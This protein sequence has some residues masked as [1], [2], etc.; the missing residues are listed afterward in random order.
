MNQY[1]SFN[2]QQTKLLDQKNNLEKGD[3]AIKKLLNHLDLKKDEAIM[4]TFRSVQKHFAVVFKELV[5]LGKGC[6]VLQR[7]DDPDIDDNDL[8]SDDDGEESSDD[9]NDDDDDDSSEDES[10]ED[11]D[12]DRSMLDDENQGSSASNSSSS[13]SLNNSKL[14]RK[15]MR[16]AKKAAKKQKRKEERAKKMHQKVE[17]FSGVGVKVT[18]SGEG[19]TSMTKR[20][21]GGQKDI[22]ALALI[23][24]I[25]RCDPGP[26][27][28]FDELDAALDDVRRAAVAHLISKQAHD[29]TN[30]V[31]FITSTFRPELVNVADS[32]IGVSQSKKASVVRSLSKKNAAAFMMNPKIQS[33]AAHGKIEHQV[34][35]YYWMICY[36]L[37]FLNLIFSYIFWTTYFHLKGP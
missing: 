9:D 5:P 2:D 24:S 34:S 30:P 22:V 35:Y 10:S 7:K 27:Y 23:L 29:E 26:F 36:L 16:K 4:T 13:S 1:V 31:Q 3:G 18:F 15:K 14:S 17:S 25:Q 37:S 32:H 12:G 8:L 6:L 33:T 11:E 28:L 20:L 21:S 19:E